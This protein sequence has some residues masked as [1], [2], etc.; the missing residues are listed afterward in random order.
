MLNLSYMGRKSLC[1]DSNWKSHMENDIGGR[2]IQMLWKTASLQRD[3]L[4]FIGEVCGIGA[5][6]LL[7]NP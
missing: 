5:D 7:G 6:K 2:G 3:A 4:S 1:I